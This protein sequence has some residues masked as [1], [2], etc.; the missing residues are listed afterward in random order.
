MRARRATRN[1]QEE[2]A[3][4]RPPPPGKGDRDR[5]PRDQYRVNH[6]IRV[7]E[8]RVVLDDGTQLGIL[9]RD[10]AL[11]L[12]EEKGLDL[13]EIAARSSP[14]VCRIMD[15][16]RFKYEQSK[17]QKQARKHASAMELKE[18]KFRPK[19]EQHD[20][21]FKINH[22]RR[23]LEEGNKCRL[24]IVFRGREITHPETGVKVLNR[25]VEATQD[26]ATVEVRPSLEGKRM[27]MILG[28]RAGVVKRA[29]PVPAP[30]PGAPGPGPTQV[31]APGAGEHAPNP[32]PEQ[33]E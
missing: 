4:I 24:V 31:P 22:V 19:T 26:I 33:L 30:T 25:V 2:R 29:K 5:R 12:A 6:R 18:I 21:D 15:Y 13:V 14:P 23:F 17:K 11:R 9:T 27:M 10:E 32:P 8:V 16:G 20:M 7:P 1:N 3:A 28:P